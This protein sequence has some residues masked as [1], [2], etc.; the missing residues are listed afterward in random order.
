MPAGTTSLQQTIVCAAATCQPGAAFHTA[1]TVVTIDDPTTPTVA[2]AGALVSGRWVRAVQRITVSGKDTTGIA[3]TWA[4]LGSKT[5]TTQWACRYTS[6][7]P[8]ADHGGP[9]DVDTVG[10]ASGQHQ[11]TVGSQ[12]AAGN[13]TSAR[14]AV[15]VDNEPPG[16]VRPAVIG[17]DAWRRSDGFGIRWDGTPELHAPI[18][19]TWYRLC[20]SVTCTTGAV[21]GNPGAL[22]GIALGESGEHTIQVWLEDEAGNQAYALSASE[23]VV[24]RLDREAPRLSFEPQSDADPLRVA[25]GVDDR[26][27]GLDTGEIE[28]RERG[29]N[30]WH[31][32]ATAREGRSLVGYVDDERFRS[33]TFDFRARARDRAGNEASTDRRANGTRA[34]IDLPARSA[35]RLSIGRRR[36]LRRGGKQV[37]RVDARAT[38]L[39]ATRLRLQGRLTD[40]HGQALGGATVQVSS[41]SPGDAVGLVPE[42]LAR[43]DGM[44]RFTYVVRATRN[45]VVRFRYA[46]TRRIRGATGDFELRVPAVSSIRARPARLRNGQAVQLTGL[47]RTGPLPPAG[48]LIEVQ[49]YFRGRFRTFSTTRA[50]G[51]GRWAFAYRFGGTRG[52]VPYRL[53]ALLPAEGGYPFVTGRSPVIRVIVVGA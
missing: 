27:S 9:L 33:G 51:R 48:K 1:S 46:G 18:A 13:V 26:L 4:T 15:R 53:R 25:V 29:G 35:T 43:T 11:L 7:Q 45:K 17:G 30:V 19:R 12:D 52:R 32:L 31:S 50:D 49:A 14:F 2:A 40:A 5:L 8:C 41:D 22:S 10:V 3:K 37:V 42:G 34:T 44:G 39:H 21:A 16:R 20:G 6:P 24:L 38:A 47:V 36:T 28:I 23:P